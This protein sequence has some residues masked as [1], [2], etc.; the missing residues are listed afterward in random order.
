VRGITRNVKEDHL[1]EIFDIYA[2]V[3]K[4]EIPINYGSKQKSDFAVIEFESI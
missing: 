3:K 1:K 4:V 2:K